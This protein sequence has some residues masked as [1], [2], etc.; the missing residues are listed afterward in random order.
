LEG[1]YNFAQKQGFRILDLGISSEN[2]LPNYGLIRFKENL[3]S[4][5]ALKL[6]FEK[7][8]FDE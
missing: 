2:S 1:V 5:S 6:S 4:Y 8:I 7:Q 3:G